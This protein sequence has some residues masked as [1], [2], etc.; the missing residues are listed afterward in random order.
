MNVTPPL[1]IASLTEDLTR[2][3][4]ATTA[5][6][7]L[8][9]RLSSALPLGFV[10]WLVAEYSSREGG[11]EKRLSGPRAN[12]ARSNMHARTPFAA[13]LGLA[14]PRA[15][16]STSLGTHQER[17]AQPHASCMLQVLQTHAR[18][19]RQKKNQKVSV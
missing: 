19:T 17:P 1:F 14:T 13:L 7:Q 5:L 12:I 2:C 16:A 11:L 15:P 9:R 10:E 6:R 4:R 3:A 18:Y 8:V